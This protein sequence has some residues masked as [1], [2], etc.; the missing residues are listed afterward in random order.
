MIQD[1]ERLLRQKQPLFFSFYLVLLTQAERLDKCTIA[2]DV[3]VV[4]ILQQL[5]TATYHLCQ[6]AGGTKVLV[7]LLQV[8]SEVSD[9]IGEQSHLA[10][11]RTSVLGVLAILAEDLSLLCGI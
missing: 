4:E 3:L 9:T 11:N 8:L 7:I 10:L 2:I 5:T 1:K 6:G